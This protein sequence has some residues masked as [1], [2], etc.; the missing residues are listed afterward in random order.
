MIEDILKKR[1]NNYGTFE[2]NAST[3]Q[4]IKEVMQNSKYWAGMSD[5]K[6]EALEMVAHKISRIINGNPDYVDSWVDIQGYAKLGEKDCK[7]G[8]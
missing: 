7:G 5:S 4:A 1:G 3:T 6:K 8:L 2:D